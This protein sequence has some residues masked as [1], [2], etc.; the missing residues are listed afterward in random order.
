MDVERVVSIDDTELRRDL[1]LIWKSN[2]RQYFGSDETF[3]DWQE[4]NKL[5][6]QDLRNWLIMSEKRKERLTKYRLVI[7]KNKIKTIC[8]E[9]QRIALTAQ[10]KE[11][12]EDLLTMKYLASGIPYSIGDIEKIFEDFG[13]NKIT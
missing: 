8:A 9:M 11:Y 4:Y 2:P 7:L 10:T 5:I 13:Y 1:A 3:T 12:R 6:N